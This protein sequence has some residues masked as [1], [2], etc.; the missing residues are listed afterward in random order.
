MEEE[1]GE[2]KEKR[3]VLFDKYKEKIEENSDLKTKLTLSEKKRQ[4]FTTPEKN[5]AEKIEPA[6]N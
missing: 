4:E 2:F 1:I 6:S 5:S 3:S